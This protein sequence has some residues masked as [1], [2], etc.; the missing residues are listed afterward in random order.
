M[1]KI[2]KMLVSVLVVGLVLTSVHIISA[3]MQDRRLRGNQQQ[4]QQMDP[5]QMMERIMERTMR[6]L[7]LSEEEGAVLQPMIKG[8]LQKRMDQGTK[9]R[10]A[11]NALREAINAKDAEK[12]KVKLTEIK[13]VR[14]K[15][16]EESDKLEKE[17]TELLTL[18]QEAQ[19]TVS[20]TINSDGSGMQF[21]GG[22]PQGMPGGMMQRG[23]RPG[24]GRQRPQ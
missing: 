12:V 18:V 10:E 1:R 6:P 9:R 13:A 2:N 8:L 21:G 5:A 24:G 11:I 17:L 23:D 4:R 7:N 15:H 3:Q 22:R 19:L 16:R 14:K 20:G